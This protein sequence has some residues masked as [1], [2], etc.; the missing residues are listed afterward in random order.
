MVRPFLKYQ[1][2]T[3]TAPDGPLVATTPTPTQLREQQWLLGPSAGSAEGEI[4][5]MLRDLAIPEAQQRIFQS[6]A[7]ALEE[8]KRVGG[9]ALTIGFAVAKDLSSGRL[10]HLKAPGLQVSG[11]W[12]AS[13]LT[14]DARQPAVSEL[15]RFITTPRCTQ[16]MIRGSGVG[17]TRFRPKVHVTLWS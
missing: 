12:C 6:E 1:I 16:A 7:A 17:V 2:I 15:L 13:T 5:T 10:A 8:V 9:V 14:P 3:V 4:A 11:E